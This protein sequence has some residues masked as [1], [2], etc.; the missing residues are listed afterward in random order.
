METKN[1]IG[2]TLKEISQF[3]DQ[4]EL[5][6]YLARE[7]LIWVY[8]KGAKSFESMT[9]VSKK[10][11]I[12]LESNFTFGLQLPHNFQESKDGTKKYLFKTI[13]QKFIETAYIPEKNRSTLCISSQVG[14]KMGCKFCMTARQGLQGQ[15]SAGD[16]LNQI[17][18]LP[19]QESLTNYVF[20]GMGEPFDNIEEVLKTLEILTSDWGMAISPRRI[21][22]STIGLLPGMK[23]FLS[24][25]KC[26]LAIS[27]HSPFDDERRK[28]MPVQ[29]MYPIS[30]VMTALRENKI[31]KPRKLSFEYILFENLNDTDNHIKELAR[32][33]NGV[34]CHVNLMHYHSIP[35]SSLNGSSDTKLIHFR[36]QLNDK[37]IVATIR[38]S[39]GMDIAAACGLLSTGEIQNQNSSQ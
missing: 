2:T 15:L 39:R 17:L 22:V 20:M 37:G 27:L 34:R 35:G 33:L 30:E 3:V 28:L 6:K 31:E 32:L 21:T 10:A 16:I 7:I 13:N 38:A 1:I 26:N 25:S 19:E 24:E 12:L 36:D 9:N 23:R 8:Q 11:R 29:R 5:P 14:C 18:S 4:H